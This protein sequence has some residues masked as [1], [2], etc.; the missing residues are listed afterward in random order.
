MWI[1]LAWC[2]SHAGVVCVGVRACLVWVL[3]CLPPA[4]TAS[5]VRTAF[6]LVLYQRHPCCSPLDTLCALPCNHLLSAVLGRG[7]RAACSYLAMSLSLSLSV[8]LLLE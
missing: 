7:P 4:A 1:P 2:A 5:A 8:L 6:S 3:A